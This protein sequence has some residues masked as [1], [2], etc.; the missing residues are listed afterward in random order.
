[1]QHS[2]ID[3]RTVERPARRTGQLPKGQIRRLPGGLRSFPPTYC[4]NACRH[5]SQTSLFDGSLVMESRMIGRSPG[6][7]LPQMLHLS[8]GIVATNVT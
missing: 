3:R 6:G 5:S 8:S 7:H 4:R 1:M 2:K